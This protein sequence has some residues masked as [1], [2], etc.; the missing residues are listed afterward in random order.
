MSTY[1]VFSTVFELRGADLQVFSRVKKKNFVQNNLGVFF[2]FKRGADATDGPFGGKEGWSTL[3]LTG[4]ESWRTLL[5][6]GIYGY[7]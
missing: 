1:A 5:W 4:V 2:S 6:L 7:A 3:F